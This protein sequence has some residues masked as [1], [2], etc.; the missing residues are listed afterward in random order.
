MFGELDK[1]EAEEILSENIFGRLGCHAFGK[2]YVVPV[3][4][5]YHE[6]ALYFHTLEGLKTQM[7]RNNPSVCF[8]VDVLEDMANWKSVIVQGNYEELAGEE[9]DAAIRVLLDRQISGSVSET[10]KLTSLWPFTDNNYQEI[11]GII[12]RIPIKEISGRFE[13][14][15]PI[16]K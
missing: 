1:K 16:R 12:F 15:T 4:Y 5:A 2:T 9:R 3:S 8:Q 11:Q 7:M 10:V 14:S 6:N 13:K